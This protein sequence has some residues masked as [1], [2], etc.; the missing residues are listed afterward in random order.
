MERRNNY[1]LR[2]MY[3]GI[4]GMKNMQTK[5]DVI[6][7]NIANVNTYGFKK[8]R[9]T[10]K[11]MMSQTVAGASASNETRGGTNPKQVGLG[12]TLATI[13]TIHDGSSLQTTN[14]SLDLGIDGDGYF[15]VRQGTAQYYT[16]A[17]NFYLDDNGLLVNG[18]GLAVQAYQYDNAGNLTNRLGDIAVN[19]NAVM[20]A[21]T[22]TIISAAG[23]LPANAIAEDTTATPPVKGFIYTQQIKVV[24]KNGNA[25]ALDVHFK[26]TGE[27]EWSLYIN[28]DPNKADSTGTEI[29][30]KADGTLDS[31]EEIDITNKIPIGK[32][33]DGN[34]IELELGDNGLTLNVSQLSQN[35][36]TASALLDP[37]G[38]TEGKL[39]S[40]NIGATGDITG[41]YSNGEIVTLG[42]LA[43]AKFSNTS[44]LMKAGNNLFQETIN[45]GTANIGAAGEGRGTLVSGSLEMSNVDLSE[46][47]TEM[48]VAQRSFQ[49][50][51]RIITTSDEILQELV[52]LKR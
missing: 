42:R 1:M 21:Q 48:I 52:N 38:S 23:N 28:Q 3:S 20:P 46:E 24:D 22:T 35:S 10:F 4:S 32:D 13:D 45:S 9:V 50:N 36:G 51:T 11:D 37:D 5:L 40:F 39:E 19:V 12:S 15:V 43:L 8:G 30:F 29:K 49:A 31:D 14:R 27:N 2:S 16:R 17:G 41:V 26:K 7:N 25:H 47:F 6:G 33:A 34:D 18:D 44:G